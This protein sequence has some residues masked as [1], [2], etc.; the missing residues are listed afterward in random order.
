M[1]RWR[2]GQR[3]G[4]W[5]HFTLVRLGREVR[6]ILDLSP[7]YICK[8]EMTGKAIAVV[9]QFFTGQAGYAGYAGFGWAR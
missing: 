5:K 4:Q 3:Q 1:R 6:A 9:A 8:N 2:E 7:D